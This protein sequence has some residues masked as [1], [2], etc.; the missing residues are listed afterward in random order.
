MTQLER[1]GA[2]RVRM[3]PRRVRVGRDEGYLIDLS[4]AGALVRFGL[5]QHPD[6]M[7]RMDLGEEPDNIRLTARVVRCA[8]HSI[9]LDG[10]VLRRQDYNVGFEFRECGSE[11]RRHL[12]RL[13]A[14]ALSAGPGE[15]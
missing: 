13:V 15:T 12:R 5:K 6:R 2:V 1:R 14:N 4:E 11:E 7:V 8:A 9:A 3:P 10:A